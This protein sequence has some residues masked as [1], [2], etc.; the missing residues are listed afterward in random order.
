MATNIK[1]RMICA[2]CKTLIQEGQTPI[3]LGKKRISHGMCQ[4]CYDNWEEVQKKLWDGEE[5]EQK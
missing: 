4:T 2:W 3:I 1:L 5:T